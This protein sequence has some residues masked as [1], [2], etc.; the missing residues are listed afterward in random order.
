[1]KRVQAEIMNSR[2]AGA[3]HAITLIA[4]E[5][6]EVARPGQ[7]I[8]VGVPADRTGLLRQALEERVEAARVVLRDHRVDHRG[9]QDGGLV[10]PGGVG[11]SVTP[12][13]SWPAASASCTSSAL[14]ISA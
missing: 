12:A 8:S 3:Y 1:M 2:R 6:A 11:H 13:S 5:I 9:R 7:F 10:D 4:P 14:G